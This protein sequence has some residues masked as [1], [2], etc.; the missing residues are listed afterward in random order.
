[1]EDNMYMY[2]YHLLILLD[3]A[4]RFWGEPCTCKLTHVCLLNMIEVHNLVHYT[5]TFDQ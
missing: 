5:N 4:K 2:I 3:K 1:M